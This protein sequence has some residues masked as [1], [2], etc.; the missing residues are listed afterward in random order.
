MLT[1]GVKRPTHLGDLPHR[2]WMCVFV[3]WPIPRHDFL[4]RGS[5]R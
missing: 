5:G 3:V 1:F 2:V 4:Y